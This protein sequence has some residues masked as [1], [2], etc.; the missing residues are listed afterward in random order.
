MKMQ[1]LIITT[2]FLYA[3]GCSSYGQ[4]VKSKTEI[5]K[6]Q[7]DSK[8]N[9]A[10]VNDSNTIIM[11][12]KLKPD[13]TIGYKTAM[14]QIEKSDVDVDFGLDE[15]MPKDEIKKLLEKY[16]KEFEKTSYITTLQWND[17]GNIGTKMFN[18]DFKE[19]DT[20]KLD[21]KDFNPEDM[22]KGVLLR[23]EINEN[24]QIESFYLQNRQK[25]MIAM[26]FEL[27]DRT[28]KIGD[29]WSLDVSFL[30]FDQSFVCK[31][32]ERTNNVE[33]I[34]ILRESSDTVAVIKYNIYESANGYMKNPM[35]QKKVETALSM[36]FTCIAEFSVTKGRWITYNGI[37]ETIQKGI[38]SVSGKQKLAL[39]PFD[40]LTKE[41]INIE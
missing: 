7:G 1:L 21:L 16:Q 5:N 24:G 12:W 11:K 40:K 36:R 19:K 18:E 20:K 38:M 27:P 28:V 37:L 31:S 29:S 34:D 15:D 35:N 26:F 32:A 41:M 30:Q 25:N 6:F 33:L 2:F 14:E 39:I 10:S 3:F 9:P 23:G 17:R 13:E 8:I 22:L 4:D